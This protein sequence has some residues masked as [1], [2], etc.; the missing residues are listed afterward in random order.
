MVNVAHDDDVATLLRLVERLPNRDR[1]C[2]EFGA[3]DGS[4]LSNTRRL[5]E[6]GGYSAVLIESDPHRYLDLERRYADIDRVTTINAYVGFTPQTGLDALLAPTD[7]PRDFDVLSIDIDGNDIHAWRAISAYRPKIVV[8]EINPTIPAAVKFEQP[9]DPK[10]MWGSSLAA[11]AD[12]AREKEHELVA[13]THDNAFFVRSDLFPLY[14]IEDN[15]PAAIRPDAKKTILFQG[16]DG[17][18][19]LAGYQELLWHHVPFDEGCV[20]QLPRFLRDFPDNY[21]PLQRFGLR[22]IARRRW[23]RKLRAT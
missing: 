7:I 19:H 11:I 1:W 15:S 5:I 3:Y 14:G 22:V 6:H 10:I 13:A 2:V 4:Y 12:V 23:R 18:I 17:S 16:F 9:C 21:G 8:I 20:Q